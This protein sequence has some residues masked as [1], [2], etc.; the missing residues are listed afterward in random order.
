MPETRY[1]RQAGFHI[2]YQVVGTGDLDLVLAADWFGN[3]ELMWDGISMAHALSRLAS[4]ARLVIFDKRG[5]GLSDPV[6]V[7]GL[8]TLEEW[9]EDVRAVMDDAGIKR[10]ALVGVG[11]GGPMA[12]QFAATHP[13]RVSALALINTYARLSRGPD[14]A[15]GIPDAVRD[16]ILDV[17]YTDDR[18]ADFLAG[19]SSDEAFRAWWRRYQRH[20]VSPATAE[21]MRRMIFD[22]DVLSVL[23]AIQ[24]PTL[25]LHRRD[26]PWIRIGHAR[27]IAETI[28]GARLVE[29]PGDEDLFFL[30]DCDSLLDQVEEFLTGTPPAVRSDRVLAT[31]LF[32]DIVESTST[33]SR[34]GD[35]RWHVVMD[36]H[37]DLVR[38]TVERFRG[39]MVISTGDGMLAIFDGPGR[40]VACAS[41]I[42][43]Q[44]AALHLPIRA[45]VHSGE[46]EVRGDDVTG[47][48]VNVAARIA[49]LGGEGEIL[50]SST[51]RDLVSGSGLSLTDRGSYTLKG[52]PEPWR[53]FQL[54]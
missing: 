37:D 36:Q 30:G 26:D 24:A 15:P 1:A 25:V 2:A 14:Y 49:A 9:I 45:G 31:M 38:R 33:A 53:V 43:E 16:R 23:A 34:L 18:A 17:S 52:V 32:T 51:V 42:R 13:H 54:T 46:V 29:L 8:P 27:R 47:I 35:R 50:V 21:V 4:F 20:S 10:A 11:A 6:S 3:V 44:L 48:A 12:M 22:I 39:R 5:V 40:A 41:A 19:S 28:P 7:S